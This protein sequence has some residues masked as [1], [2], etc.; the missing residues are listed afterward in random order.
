MA[1]YDVYISCAHKDGMEIAEKLAELLKNDGISVNIDVGFDIGN[2][3]MQTAESKIAECNC[4]IP[5]VTE[6]YIT[7]ESGKTE[8][9]FACNRSKRI[10]RIEACDA[11]Y[12]IRMNSRSQAIIG[13]NRIFRYDGQESLPRIAGIISRMIKSSAD[14]DTQYEKLNEYE[15]SKDYNNA[16]LTICQIIGIR[17][18][19]YDLEKD[20]RQ[21][22]ELTSLFIEIKRLLDR[23]SRYCSEYGIDSADA[24]NIIIDVINKTEKFLS[25]NTISKTSGKPFK[26]PSLCTYAITI[27]YYAY[28]IKSE[29][30]KQTQQAN[31]DI[32]TKEDY[33]EKQEPY[34]EVI[35]SYEKPEE[36]GNKRSFLS[37]QIRIAERYSLSLA[38][39]A[40]VKDERN[41]P[42]RIS[43]EDDVLLAVARFMR[44]GNRLFDTLQEKKLEG[45]FMQCLLISYERLKDYCGIVGATNIEKEC[46]RRIREIDEI[47]KKQPSKETE[48]GKAEQ[49]IKS[50]LGIP[51]KD[52]KY[53]DVFI[54]FK[55]ED[56]DMAE[57]IYNYCNSLL[58][59]PFWSKRSLPEL[60]KS[61][62][63]D[64]IYNALD[65]SKHFVVVLSKLEYLNSNWVREEM[66]TFHSDKLEGRKGKES[67]FIFVVTD[68]LYETI[69][70]CKKTCLETRF[71]KYQII[72]MSEYENDLIQYLN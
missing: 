11:N 28:I 71:R 10:I 41:K 43:T 8:L 23:L 34:F 53:Y 40:P 19:N 47:V 12:N 60:S 65:K 69:T 37:S 25:D 56:I 33:A 46:E 27:L 26:N 66:E 55:S 57:T 54:S 67:N 24:L 39:E 20:S 52:S 6:A 31:A 14:V 16:A 45:S 1:R 51:Q 4:F 72:K 38:S 18:D 35:R 36:E 58:K 5:I 49:G 7:S 48:D 44:D 68:D 63:E 62:Y 3:W 70:K 64:A 30:L 61:E 59:Q 50:L 22:L 15:K 42:E 21:K 29:C 9:E 13:R 32:C 17:I 2:D